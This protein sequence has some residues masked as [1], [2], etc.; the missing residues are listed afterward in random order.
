MIEPYYDGERYDF[1]CG[2]TPEP[3][4]HWNRTA[5][6]LLQVDNRPPESNTDGV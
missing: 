5:G 6:G 3:K 1:A 4:S 2:K